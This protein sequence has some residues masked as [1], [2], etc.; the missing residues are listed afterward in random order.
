[1]SAWRVSSAAT[2]SSTSASMDAASRSPS[3]LTVQT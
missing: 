3:E 1:L 2:P